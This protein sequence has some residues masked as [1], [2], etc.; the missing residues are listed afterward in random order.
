VQLDEPRDETPMTKASLIRGLR[1]VPRRFWVWLVGVSI[2]LLLGV[3]S[4]RVNRYGPGSD[5]HTGFLLGSAAFGTEDLKGLRCLE[6]HVKSLDALQHGFVSSGDNCEVKDLQAD[7]A[8]EEKLGSL[9][10]ELRIG[11]RDGWRDERQKTFAERGKLR[12]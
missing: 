3:Y 2:V 5:Y 1:T 4:C 10:D 7:S 8:M 6:Q 9:P 11:F 12:K